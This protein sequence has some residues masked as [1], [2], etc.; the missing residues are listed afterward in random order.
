M[1]KAKVCLL[2][3]S[4]LFF[5]CGKGGDYEQMRKQLM[6]A[7]TQNENYEPFSSDSTMLRVADYFDRNGTANEKIMAHYLL[8]CVYRDLGDMPRS[9]ECY[10]QAV[11]K[12]DTTDA[13]C[14]YLLLGKVHGQMAYIY[15]KE[16]LPQYQLEQSCLCRRYSLLAGDTL[17]AIRAE[18]FSAS[19]Y[20]LLDNADSCIAIKE[21][22]AEL[23]LVH[24]ENLRFAEAHSAL[25]AFYLESGAVQKAATSLAKTEQTKE[26][27]LP[28]GNVIGG[29]EIFYYNKGLL[30]LAEGD[31]EKAEQCFRRLAVVADTNVNKRIAAARG[32][33]L[34]FEKQGMADSTAKYA[35]MAYAL[36]DTINQRLMQSALPTM[37]A[38]YDY[39]RYKDEAS[40]KSQE[41][42]HT[43]MLVLILVSVLLATVFV[44][45]VFISK[46]RR[47][48]QEELAQQQHQYEMKMALLSKAND[49]LDALLAESEERNRQLIEQKT[50]EIENYKRQIAAYK[51]DG[52]TAEERVVCSS[53]V[54]RFLQ[55]GKMATEPTDTDWEELRKLI[56]MEF[57]EFYGIMNVN[58]QLPMVEYHICIL[59][60]L[61]FGIKEMCNLTGFDKYKMSKIRRHL[62]QKVYQKDGSSSDF[63]KL[64]RKVVSITPF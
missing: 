59:I 13:D 30:H 2:L 18:D 9:L 38:L 24:G 35:M 15:N 1:T 63:D 25:T 23:Y 60:K 51:N 45:Y 22:C 37:Q 33:A 47:R 49:D 4:L 56:N 34:L 40:K 39:S 31:T 61:G 28:N 3:L 32:L 8:G 53:V 50:T 64:V 42:A 52:R 62:L 19:A 46:T 29:R 41:A 58:G 5:A 20:Y 12:A 44:A 16:L 14:D 11:G 48:K 27:F 55:M 21:R 36:N 17:A 7:K 10:H 26:F 6:K 43:K 54:K 57:P